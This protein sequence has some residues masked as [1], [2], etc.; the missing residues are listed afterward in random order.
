MDKITDRSL[1]QDFAIEILK[2]VLGHNFADTINSRRYYRNQDN[3]NLLN[4]KKGF[5]FY[6]NDTD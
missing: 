4:V 3:F 5:Q 2:Y 1:N 6:L